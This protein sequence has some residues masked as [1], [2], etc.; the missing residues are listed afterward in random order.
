MHGWCIMWFVIF[1]DKQKGTR[2][3]AHKNKDKASK[4]GDLSMTEVMSNV[5][6]LYSSMRT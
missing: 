5:I 3:K 6:R 1:T 4:K 2:G